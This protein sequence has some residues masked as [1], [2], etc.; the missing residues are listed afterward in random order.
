MPLSAKEPTPSLFSVFSRNKQNCTRL[1]TTNLTA[2]NQDQ[3]L[4]KP[5]FVQNHVRGFENAF[6]TDYYYRHRMLLFLPKKKTKM[7]FTKM[8]GNKFSFAGK[9]E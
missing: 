2:A 3:S 8:Q 6:F 9:E 5:D 7:V 4:S 1:T